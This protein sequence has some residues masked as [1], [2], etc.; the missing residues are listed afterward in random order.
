MASS[1]TE[2]TE[3]NK[4][5]AS[6]DLEQERLS[7]FLRF[8]DWISLFDNGAH[9]YLGAQVTCSAL[10]CLSVQDTATY[11]E[12]H[13]ENIQRFVFRVL[14]KKKYFAQDRLKTFLG[15]NSTP[16]PECTLA[17]HASLVTMVAAETNDN[18]LELKR[19]LGDPVVYGAIVQFELQYSKQFLSASSSASAEREAS[20]MRVEL[21]TTTARSCWFRINPRFKLRSEG[22]VVMI[23]DQVVLESLEIA[24]QAIH[25]SELLFDTNRVDA[26]RREVNLS[27]TPST[28]EIRHFRSST[29][30]ATDAICGGDVIQLFHKEL[31]AYLAAE[32]FSSPP[33]VVEDAHLRVRY[34]D[35]SRPNRYE[36]PTSCPS[37]WQVELHDC[38][39]GDA[40]QWSSAVRLR[41]IATGLYLSI[42]KEGHLTL[43]E[44]VTVAARLAFHF[45]PVINDGS[46]VA[47]TST[48]VRLEHAAT[49]CWVHGDAATPHVRGNG[50]ASSLPPRLPLAWDRAPL[51]RVRTTP[52][53]RFDDAFLVTKVSPHLV[54]QCYFVSGVLA[55]LNLFSHLAAH[56]S[57]LLSEMHHVLATVNELRAYLFDKNVPIKSR[58]K[59]IRNLFGVDTLLGILKCLDL[60]SDP[61]ASASIPAAFSRSAS[62]PASRSARA[63]L[64]PPRGA[65][66]KGAPASGRLSPVHTSTTVSAASATTTTSSARLTSAL[67]STTLTP[68]ARALY[69]V[70]DKGKN[71]RMK[72]ELRTAVCVLLQAYVE[73]A[74][75]KN[76]LYLARNIPFFQEHI[77][78]GNG[79]DRLFT[80]LVSNNAKVIESISADVLLAF[81]ATAERQ[82]SSDFLMFFN[83]LC[84]CDGVTM[85]AIQHQLFD[86]LFPKQ[87]GTRTFA[88]C[89]FR[90]RYE[91]QELFVKYVTAS[92][93]LSVTRM[94]AEPDAT[95][96]GIL[97]YFQCQLDLFSSLCRDRNYD[98]IQFFSGNFISAA[99]TFALMQDVRIPDALRGKLVKYYLHSAV[100]VGDNVDVLSQT[101][102]SF[103]WVRCKKEPFADAI[104]DRTLALC[105]A[106]MLAFP[107]LCAWILREVTLASSLDLSAVDRNGFLLELMTLC[108]QLV[109]FGYYAAPADISNLMPA[110]VCLLDGL[111]DVLSRARGS[112]SNNDYHKL[113][114]ESDRFMK[115]AQ[116]DIVVEIKVF[117]LK[118]IDAMLN[119]IIFLRVQSFLFD[120]KNIM[121]DAVEQGKPSKELQVQ[122][123]LLNAQPFEREAPPSG[124]VKLFYSLTGHTPRFTRHGPVAEYL[125]RVVNSY[126]WVLPN[127]K[128]QRYSRV[129]NQSCDLVEILLDLGRYKYSKLQTASITVLHRL[130]SVFSDLFE[131]LSNVTLLVS[132]SDIALADHMSAVLPILRRLTSGVVKDTEEFSRIVEKL[133]AHLLVSPTQPHPV[134]QAMAVGEGILHV[135]FDVLRMYR[136]QHH[137]VLN[138][139]FIA[140]RAVVLQN[141]RV[142]LIV[143]ERIQGLFSPSELPA[144][145]LVEFA[146]FLTDLLQGND[147][148][149]MSVSSEFIHFLFR[150][151]TRLGPSGHALLRIVEY[152]VK[153]SETC[154]IVDR[155]QI[156]VLS[157]FVQYREQLC[158]LTSLSAAT[159]AARRQQ[160]HEGDSDELHSHNAAISLLAVC[161]EGTNSYIESVCNS[162][163]SVDDVLAILTDPDIAISNKEPYIR[164][165]R[166]VFL[167]EKQYII[168]HSLL[169]F[170]DDLSLWNMLAQLA[171]ECLTGPGRHSGVAIDAFIPLFTAVVE[172]FF[173]EMAEMTNVCQTVDHVTGLCQNY[174]ATA[175]AALS[176]SYKVHSIAKCL[177]TLASVT[178]RVALNLLHA[179]GMKMFRL[180][181]SDSHSISEQLCIRD[182]AYALHFFLNA[183]LQELAQGL[184]REYLG[185]N[186]AEHQLGVVAHGCG[187]LRYCE[188]EKEDEALPLGVEFQAQVDLI[189]RF[190]KGQRG[191]VPTGFSPA[192]LAVLV[193]HLQSSARLYGS[194]PSLQQKH[195]GELDRRT[196]QVLRAAVHNANLLDQL[197]LAQSLKESIADA[198][199]VAI[200]KMAYLPNSAVAREALSLMIICLTGPNKR[201]Q[202]K[203][204]EYLTTT[205]DELFIAGSQRRLRDAANFLKERRALRVQ[206]A[207]A[208]ESKIAMQRELSFH[209]LQSLRPRV[210][211]PGRRG[212]YQQMTSSKSPR[213][214]LGMSRTAA[215]TLPA[216]HARV[217]PQRSTSPLPTIKEAWMDTHEGSAMELAELNES[218]EVAGTGDAPGL[219]VE[220]SDPFYTALQL[221]FLQLLCEGHYTP[222]QN[223]LREQ[224][225]FV[226]SRNLVVQCI[227]FLQAILLE[228]SIADDELPLLQQ[229]LDTI[230]EF[231][232]G[233]KA[234]QMAAFKFDIVDAVNSLL[235]NRVLAALP[236]SKSEHIFTT[237]AL[238]LQSLIEE[239]SPENIATAHELTNLLDM[240]QLAGRMARYYKQY[241]MLRHGL[242]VHSTRTAAHVFKDIAFSYFKVL[243]RLVDLIGYDIEPLLTS[244]EAVRTAYE[245]L[246][247]QT[248]SVE[249][250]RDGQ[251]HRVHFMENNTL[252]LRKEIKDEL[253]WK[254]DR[255][256]P[257]DKI[258]DFV[259]RCRVIIADIDYL[260]WVLQLT[261]LTRLIINHSHHW[262]NAFHLATLLLNLL[263][264]VTWQ[265]PSD[266]LITAPD[267]TISWF[268]P[269]FYTLAGIHFVLAFIITLT[270]FLVHPLW[271]PR[272]VA[273]FFSKYLFHSNNN[274]F[275]SAGTRVSIYSTL[276]LH[277]LA[278]VVFSVLG[279]LTG[280]YFYCFHLLHI[281]VNND[282]LSRVIQSVTKNGR[283]L[284]WVTVL[285][286]IVIYIYSIVS[287]AFLRRHFNRDDGAFCESLW[288][289]FVTSVNQGPRNGGGL[290][291]VLQPSTLSFVEP[292]LRVLFDLSFFAVVNIIGLNVVFGIIVDTFSELRDERYTIMAADESE[293]FICSQKSAEFERHGQGFVH[294][295]R[296]E[297]NMWHYLQFFMHLKDKDPSEYSSHEQ[298]VADCLEAGNLAMFPI[299]RAL[300]LERSSLTA[301]DEKMSTINAKLEAIAAQVQELVGWRR[302]EQRRRQKLALRVASETEA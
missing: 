19:R 297:H 183:K 118:I 131:Q 235:R 9:G 26:G 187:K 155:N 28:F 204:V 224:P 59:L 20:A 208:A 145:V 228:E 68:A 16:L 251:L 124:L 281:T 150:L 146:R 61:A 199:A 249:I 167:G 217:G 108:H 299:N 230:V 14:P 246:R 294:H 142:Q 198:A 244:S 70:D 178:D 161:A 94:H 121:L 82:R 95:M 140:L 262:T 2:S 275:D 267:H 21:A 288:E 42:D 3:L 248:A 237:V 239:N 37:F 151:Y 162:I 211:H 34:E 255:T 15:E 38:M 6:P 156:L 10:S 99:D 173:S 245:K 80:Q 152:I 223:L 149:R 133:A 60:G 47:M 257:Q 72:G 154:T 220:T 290:G 97:D 5:E 219:N 190:E 268:N 222:M 105:N 201:M 302:L 221:R 158:A 212:Q 213:A 171:D 279:L 27:V 1:S 289:C 260:K 116:N 87:S 115:S 89:F 270:F 179:T 25:V 51:L 55:P 143:Y 53:Q 301:E 36:P 45:H 101:P 86:L 192:D 102:L 207:K 295:R 169:R 29:S 259:N 186:T 164:F 269:V 113:W 12:G 85:T 111:D 271:M 193:K 114:L 277:H 137:A 185:P 236:Y 174:L 233:C 229:C 291:D 92:E 287:F 184:R 283:S 195:L 8:G 254:V 132:S 58:Q 139:S 172:I 62:L 90:L 175:L 44:A 202:A 285:I 64:A 79:M 196:L 206:L 69:R 141:P 231:L 134:H 300:A 226:H 98:V 31:S 261:P 48:L 52:A 234:N 176:N 17:E 81:L 30:M 264:L 96:E 77:G 83:A 78:K 273:H 168:K 57:L 41:H 119:Y 194:L 112:Y 153:D 7:Q 33:Q 100:N 75:P 157:A 191:L 232:Q 73:G 63:P 74:C 22:D 88:K 242:H 278:L 170:L 39:A 40:V 91:K 182:P 46:P 247:S 214:A 200:L 127:W 103:A 128:P 35:G 266:P 298:Y 197:T 67:S 84:V 147:Q 180:Q 292:G 227:D 284:L 240:K 263:I 144:T 253:K 159:D 203:Y 163:L 93:W 125:H 160:L 117:G 66:G 286:I 130:H 104:T 250:V 23:G 126:D 177:S 129:D 256:S 120:F 274:I 13:L 280:G 276:S 123:A 50:I 225:G 32:G 243:V 209:E 49:A 216:A 210:K 148:L 43:R 11:E 241:R 272:F 238:L 110:L 166:H 65:A 24:G 282:L 252:Y 265:A 71:E 138:S 189:L 107:E 181:R 4:L 76:E 215:S 218:L 56:R 135:L 122:L 188:D 258:G 205:R 165:M 296:H 136:R 106:R 54:T 293:C 109:L 18:D